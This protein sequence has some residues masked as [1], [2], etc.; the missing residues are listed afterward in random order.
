MLH[1]I[2]T[3]PLDLYF[4]AWVRIHSTDGVASELV[5][6]SVVIFGIMQRDGQQEST[7]FISEFSIHFRKIT[8]KLME[9]VNTA[10][11]W[12]ASIPLQL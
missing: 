10:R 9:H 1:T 12:C 3:Q 5:I 6:I 8:R 2:P 7:V 11:R 4:S